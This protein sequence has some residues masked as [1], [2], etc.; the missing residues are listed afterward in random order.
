MFQFYRDMELI[1]SFATRDR[2]RLAKAINK[3][4]GADTVHVEEQQD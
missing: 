4:T 3:H 2:A 1:D